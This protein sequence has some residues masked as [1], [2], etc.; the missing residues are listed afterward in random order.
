MA[1]A[2]IDESEVRIQ[3]KMTVGAPGGMILPVGLGIGATQPVHETMSPTR[4]AGRPLMI[5]VELP[6]ATMPGP[7]GTHGGIV[8]TLVIEVIVAA[9]RLQIL[10]VGWVALMIG[11]GIGGC[12]TGVGTGAGG[13]IGA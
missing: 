1:L 9:S 11:C 13:W 5:T 3:R 4:A 6:L 8:H 2:A 12:G 10:I 7:L